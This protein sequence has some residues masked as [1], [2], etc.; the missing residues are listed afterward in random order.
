MFLRAQK[1]KETKDAAEVSKGKKP[2]VGAAIASSEVILERAMEV[3]HEVSVQ[4]IG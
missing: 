3:G 1:D 4:E 2:L